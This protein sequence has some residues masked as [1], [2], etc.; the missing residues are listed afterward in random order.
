MQ[1]KIM[2]ILKLSTSIN[3][4]SKSTAYES[5]FNLATLNP[6]SL[7][8]KTSGDEF[9]IEVSNRR[10]IKMIKV[11]RMERNRAILIR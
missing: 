3:T 6:N 11:L 8:F 4:K 1:R 5:E 9:Y 2:G 7:A 10:N